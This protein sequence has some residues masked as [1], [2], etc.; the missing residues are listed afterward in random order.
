MY[1]HIKEPTAVLKKSISGL[2][3]S[4]TVVASLGIFHGKIFGT[5]TYTKILQKYTLYVVVVMV[6]RGGDVYVC[7]WGGA[8][9][10][11]KR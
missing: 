3:G 7:V 10:I 2:H 11:S 5:I 1:V 8:V 4:A 9:S 6:I